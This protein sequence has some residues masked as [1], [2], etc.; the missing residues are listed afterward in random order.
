ML[1][2]TIGF[3]LLIIG[4]DLLVKGSSNIAQKFHIPEIL[5]GLTIVALGTSMPELIITITSANK[6]AT[7]LIIGN[8]I[9]SNLCNLLLILGIIAILKPIVIDKETKFI[10]LPVALFS[11]I[12]IACLGLGIL[13]STNNIISRTDGIILVVLYL[14]YFL[15]PIIIEIKDIDESMK[16]NKKKHIKTKGILVSVLFIIIGIVALKNGGE[17]VVNEA[18]KIAMNYGVSESI[19][20]LTIVAIGTALPELI[21]SIIA[22]IKKEDNLAVGN[23]IG[24]CI[25]N[26]FLILGAGA[27]I[28]PLTFSSEFIFNLMLLIFSIILILGCCFIGKK[29]TITRYNAIL[30]LALY[31]GYV[32]SLFK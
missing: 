28:T 4:A 12:V 6:N 22:V 31:L 18:T 14:L 29:N 10:H 25:L 30:L 7:D 9:G 13:G 27:I 21:T 24:S 20:G 16:E 3:L 32:V 5:I 2:L 15:Y 11:A 8:A 23:L 26:S 1:M 19:I 17:I